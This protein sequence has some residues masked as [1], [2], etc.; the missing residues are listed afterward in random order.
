M[1]TLLNQFFIFADTFFFLFRIADFFFNLL[2]L[3]ITGDW[4]C[5]LLNDFYLF[6]IIVDLI[7]MEVNLG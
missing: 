5:I 4:I 1:D 6:S 3:S 2:L 7:K